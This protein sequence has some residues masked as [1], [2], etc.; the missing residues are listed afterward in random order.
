[1]TSA[2]P[3]THDLLARLVEYPGSSFFDDVVECR[4]CLQDGHP[5]AAM[6]VL[7]F[8]ETIR[9]ESVEGVDEL[10]TRTFDI[11]PVCSLEVGWQ[12]YGEN[13]SRG[14]FL[15]SMRKMLR[16]YE[17][18][19]SSELP[20]HLTHVLPVLARLPEQR[21]DEFATTCVLPAVEKMLK[22]LSGKSNPYANVIEAIR[23]VLATK[24]RSNTD[25]ADTPRG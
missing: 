25:C 6:L 10:F 11:N 19:E 24:H 7:C 17:V 14:E 13:Y 4:K 8:E 3:S 22:G 15:V 18:P 2:A 20:D 16:D 23:D 9:G 5:E 12:L 1:M 21:A